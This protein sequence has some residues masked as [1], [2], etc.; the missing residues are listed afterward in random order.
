MTAKTIKVSGCYDDLG[1]IRLADTK[2]LEWRDLCTAALPNIPYGTDVE[3]V[4]TYEEID[5]LNGRNGIVWATH[6]RYQADAIHD[7]LRVQDL[8][9][10]V[11]ERPMG[12]K[13][14]YLLR[15]ENSRKA[16]AAMDFIWRDDSGLILRPD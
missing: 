3:V 13:S 4:V 16:D 1:R 15:V 10:S 14:L 9:S 7:A 6:D 2:T 8:L 11:D 12:N 5:Y